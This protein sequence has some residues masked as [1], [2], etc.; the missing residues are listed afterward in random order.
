MRV[1]TYNVNFSSRAVDTEYE[2]KQ[3]A[4][5]LIAQLHRLIDEGKNTVVLIQEAMPEYLIHFH[6][7][8][9]ETHTMWTEST[10]NEA[11][12]LLMT[13]IPK[14]T[15]YEH[16]SQNILGRPPEKCR[17]VWD[18]VRLIDYEIFIINSHMPM[19]KAFRLPLSEHIASRAASEFKDATSIIWCGDFNAFP[20][21]LGYEQRRQ[22]Q[23]H[24]FYDA[25]GTILDASSNRRILSTFFGYPYDTFPQPLYESHLDHIFVRGNVKHAEARTEIL[26]VIN[27]RYC[28]SD[29]FPVWIDIA[30]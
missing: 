11:G 8:F 15:R 23:S 2:W 22:I 9:S 27:G 14:G 21:E 16:F 1:L 6:A 18:V 29:H 24:G 30:L 3:R 17:L 28:P 7:A 10:G 13:M 19:D 4:P 12:R 26:P 5:E 20:D 25:T